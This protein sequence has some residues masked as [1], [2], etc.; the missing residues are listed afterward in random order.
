MEYTGS[1]PKFDVT[2]LGMANTPSTESFTKNLLQ[3]ILFQAVYDALSK[4]FPTS[5]RGDALEW[6]ADEDNQV[7]QLCLSVCNIDHENL[8]LRVSKQGWNLDL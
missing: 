3:G 5:L 4:G 6:L 8:L 1:A 2:E 7:L